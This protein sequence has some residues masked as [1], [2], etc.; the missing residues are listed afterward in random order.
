MRKSSDGKSE[1]QKLFAAILLR[2]D[3]LVRFS[4]LTYVH[5]RK[6]RFLLKKKVQS[7]QNTSSGIT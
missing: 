4:R 3:Y 6:V 1:E 5:L 2:H 7:G